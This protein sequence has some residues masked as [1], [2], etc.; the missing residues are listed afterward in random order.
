MNLHPSTIAASAEE[1]RL[2][3]LASPPLC[4]RGHSGFANACPGISLTPPPKVS[5]LQGDRGETS[6]RFWHLLPHLR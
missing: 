5:R 6:R 3:L 2:D 4:E 1:H